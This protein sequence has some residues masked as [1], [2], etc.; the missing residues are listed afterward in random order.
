MRLWRDPSRVP[1][2]TVDG[3]AGRGTVASDRK[4]GYEGAQAG[5]DGSPSGP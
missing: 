5:W 2:L 3:A 1:A 4:G